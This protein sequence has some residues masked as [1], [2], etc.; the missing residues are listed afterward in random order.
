MANIPIR[1]KTV[2]EPMFGAIGGM[3]CGDFRALE[4]SFLAH[5]KKLDNKTKTKLRAKI[6]Q[7]QDWFRQKNIEDIDI[8][9]KVPSEM[10]KEKISWVLDDI[11]PAWEEMARGNL[12]P[13]LHD[14]FKIPMDARII[15][16]EKDLI[17]LLNSIDYR[18][19]VDTE[20]EY[21]KFYLGKLL[22][23]DILIETDAEPVI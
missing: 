11:I 23:G 16:L 10:A 20:L 3:V 21:T 12:M 5:N 6:A 13:L 9:T 14:Y 2:L 17:L 8:E 15:S 1:I 19:C 7:L 18:V 22:Q 4:R